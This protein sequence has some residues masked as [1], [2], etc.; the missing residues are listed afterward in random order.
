[1]INSQYRRH[2]RYKKV[3]ELLNEN[4]YSVSDIFKITNIPKPTIYNMIDDLLKNN[5]ITM[6]QYSF[7]SGGNHKRLFKTNN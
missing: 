1:M 3:I 6:S 2:L 5:V 4:E 7:S